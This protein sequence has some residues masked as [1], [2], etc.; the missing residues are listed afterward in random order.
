MPEVEIKFDCAPDA[1]DRLLPRVLNAPPQDRAL[2]SHDATVQGR[3]HL[4]H[5]IALV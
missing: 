3:L 4:C 1:I 5:V 2:L